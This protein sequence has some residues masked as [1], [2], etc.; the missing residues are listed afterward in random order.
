MVPDWQSCSRDLPPALTCIPHS[1]LRWASR[2]FCRK[3]WCTPCIERVCLVIFQPLY[4][5]C[6]PRSWRYLLSSWVYF[7]SIQ[8]LSKLKLELDTVY[9]HWDV[10]TIFVPADRGQIWTK[11]TE[12]S[13]FVWFM[14]L[15]STQGTAFRGLSSLALCL[16]NFQLTSGGG[17]KTIPDVTLKSVKYFVGKYIWELKSD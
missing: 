5:N 1:A 7:R 8:S 14:C 13:S 17:L 16:I 15:H 4:K 6:K 9:S 3:G 10:V 11:P 2:T 12:K